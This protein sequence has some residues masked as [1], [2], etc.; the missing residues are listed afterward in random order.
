MLAGKHPKSES[1]P[2]S[3]RV[4]RVNDDT[5]LHIASQSLK[6][7]RVPYVRLNTNL[8]KGYLKGNDE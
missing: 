4:I 7:E 6:G 8:Y 3:F 5:E 2:D 1:I